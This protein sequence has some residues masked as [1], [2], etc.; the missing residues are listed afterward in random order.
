MK[1][2]VRLM[3]ALLA[4]GECYE[5]DLRLMAHAWGSARNA[6]RVVRSMLS[7]DAVIVRE[8]R[9]S[10]GDAIK[11]VALT[12]KGRV[13]TL[14]GMSDEYW[15]KHWDDARSPFRVSD[16]SKLER[17]LNDNRI[18][19]MMMLAGV[20]AM[21]NEKPTLY[22][23][24]DGC[25][26][27]LPE[28]SGYANSNYVDGMTDD[29][30][31]ALIEHGV[32][33]TVAEVRDFISESGSA[34]EA[35]TTYVSKARGVFISDATM[36]IVYMA[37]PGDNRIISV[38]AF[39]EQRLMDALRPVLAVTHI[40]RQIKELP[41]YSINERTN[42]RTVVGYAHG[43]P[44]ALIISDGDALVYSTANG[45]PRGKPVNSAVNEMKVT[46]GSVRYINGSGPLFR[47]VFVIPHTVNGLSILRYITT[48]STEDW[49][50]ASADIIS[51]I[52]GSAPSPDSA[53]YPY[54]VLDGDM[55]I[56]AIYLPAY[57]CR[58]LY[59]IAQRQG[60]I[61]IVTYRDMLNAIAHSV[62]CDAIYYDADTLERIDEN[63]V[64]VYALNGECAGEYALE[65]EL[66][67]RG[68]KSSPAERAELPGRFGYDS[69]VRF[70]NDIARGR[71]SAEDAADAVSGK[72]KDEPARTYVHRAQVSMLVSSDYANQ[73]KKAAKYYGMSVSAYLKKITHDQVVAD[74]QAYTD[75]L[76]ENKRG[77]RKER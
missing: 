77:W 34:T 51:H 29:E 4:L 45:G 48:A 28:R 14:D 57:E 58:E 54:T 24:M 49:L 12:K 56:P 61:A 73:I 3:R 67:K 47:R 62:R 42:E 36:Y 60:R 64:L 38:R 21:P 1:L 55:H 25:G 18:I 37:Q 66:A 33:Y 11:S 63:A 39:G 13:R 43:E 27:I 8:T 9:N 70:W 52:A 41:R 65:Q 74:A 31:K 32:Y 2:E 68:V 7:S 53:M 23:L 6:K 75:M 40:G 20:A 72:R 30:C 59:M 44:Y 15:V 10:D 16:Y 19:V 69:A 22:K 5:A 76:A 26:A 17:R 35:D 50:R 46:Q 71:L